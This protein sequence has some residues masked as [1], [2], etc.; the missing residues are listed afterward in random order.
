MALAARRRPARPARVGGRRRRGR[1]GRRRCCAPPPPCWCGG[2][3]SVPLAVLAA[4]PFRPPIDLS[5]SN[6]F[7]VSVAQ[8]GRLGRLLPLYF[9]LAAAGLAL[10]W[11]RARRRAARAAARDRRPGRGVLRLRL[12]VAAVGGRR[13]A[14]RRPA[15]VLHAA[16]R[17]AAG[18]AWRARRYPDWLPRALADWAWGSRRCSPPSGCGRPPPTS[19]S[20]TRPTSRSRT[21]TPTTSGSP[22]CSAT[23]ASTAATWCSAWP[24]CWRCWPRGRLRAVAAIALIALLW[25]G[26]FFSYSQSSMVALVVVTLAIAVVAGDAR[27]RRAVAAWPLWRCWRPAATRR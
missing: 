4:A 24:W 1:G 13:E 3:S 22:R 8:D 10:A 12:P 21:P 2:P 26:L 17:G 18:H 9:V 27:V 7:L 23:R 15:G 19:C 11:R 14:G 5:S 20:S 25:P 6:R 16:V